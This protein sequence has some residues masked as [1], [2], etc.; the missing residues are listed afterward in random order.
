MPRKCKKVKTSPSVLRTLRENSGYT[1]EDIAKKLKIPLETVIAIENGKDSFTLS[2]IKRLAN[3]YKYPL[4]AFF[5]DYVEPL[6]KLLNF[7]RKMRHKPKTIYFDKYANYCYCCI[8]CN[9]EVKATSPF[10]LLKL[11]K[12]HFAKHYEQNKSLLNLSVELNEIEEDVENML[13]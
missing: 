1:Q 4:A 11:A 13:I 12:E 5:S 10:T 7:T 6:P 9:K 8:V 3:L 2:Q